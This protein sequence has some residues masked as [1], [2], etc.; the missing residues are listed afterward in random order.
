MSSTFDPNGPGNYPGDVIATVV[1]NDSEQSLVVNVDYEGY[2]ASFEL[3][4]KGS[5]FFPVVI[6]KEA[7]TLVVGS[8]ERLKVFWPNVTFSEIPVMHITL[9]GYLS[10]KGRFK[11]PGMRGDYR[12]GLK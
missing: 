7:F 11:I 12:S 6:P 9:G 2:R 5:V 3:P 10:R 8:L 4:A 1:Y